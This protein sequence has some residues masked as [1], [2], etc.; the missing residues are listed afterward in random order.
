MRRRVP[1][2]DTATARE[3][4]DHAA[5]AW[6][7]MLATGNDPY[8]TEFFGPAQVA[9][10]G[11][12]AGRAVLDL[13]CGTG[14]LARELARRGAA[15]TA[16]DL[17]PRMIERARANEDE[18]TARIDYR[19]MD[20]Q[21][22]GSSLP[23]ASFD[24][25]TACVSLQD[26]PE[27][28]R[29]LAGA[30]AVLGPGGRFV[31]CNTHPCTD[32]PVRRWDA[33]PGVAEPGLTVGDYFARGPL[34]FPWQSARYLYPWVST[35]LHATLADWTGWFLDAGFRLRALEEPVPPAEAIAR[36]PE[37]ARAAIVPHFILFE[38]AKE[39]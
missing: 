15:V 27:P 9:R 26:M 35:W 25:V 30:H 34:E 16:V 3:Q 33:G 2:F 8:R 14:Y 10:C 6:D 20:A 11:D 23:P 31:V 37:L 29:A 24:L 18:V 12:V 19:V 5:E 17:S 36:W 28:R 13:G 39:P 21:E 22:V 7:R 4:W 32:T 38:L 1:T